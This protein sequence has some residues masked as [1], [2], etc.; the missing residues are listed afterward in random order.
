MRTIHE[1]PA[2]TSTARAA[3]PRGPAAGY[4][5]GSSWNDTFVAMRV[6]VNPCVPRTGPGSP[7]GPLRLTLP[8]SSREGVGVPED[9]S[10]RTSPWVG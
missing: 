5:F 2:R 10:R 3:V 1:A 8:G 4:F 7:R 9:P 6:V